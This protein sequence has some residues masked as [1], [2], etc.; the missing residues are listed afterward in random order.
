[1]ARRAVVQQEEVFD[2]A[3]K[4]AADGKEVSALAVLSALGGG[5]LTT[6]YKHLS[7]WEASRPAVVSAGNN[8]VPEA[9]QNA[10]NST[11]RV[12]A[13]EAAREVIAVRDKA[14]EDVRTAQKQFE[15]ALDVIQKLESELDAAGTEIEGQRL[16]IG[17]LEALVNETSKQNAA[18]GA[19]ATQLREQVA[20]LQNELERQ[21]KEQATM[22]ASYNEQLAMLTADHLAAVKEAAQMK[23]QADALKSQ[24]SELI[25]KLGDK[26]K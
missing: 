10:F 12:A 5:S 14:A 21:H 2:A 17:E 24:N 9:V 18:L 1:M 11:W 26:R 23:G 22:R 3:E 4:L 25:A 16:R 7:A 20:S 8:E 13:M 15:G 19:T 6:I